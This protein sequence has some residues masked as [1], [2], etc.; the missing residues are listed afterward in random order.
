MTP[1]NRTITAKK[2]YTMRSESDIPILEVPKGKKRSE[3]SEKSEKAEKAEKPEKA[4]KSD[5]S[6]KPEKS[7]KAFKV[8]SANTK[9]KRGPARPHRR[10]ATE[11]IDL[12]ITKL[13]KR[14]DR[15]KSQIEDAGRHVEGYLR[16]RDFREKEAETNAANGT[17]ASPI[18]EST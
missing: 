15:A 16:E 10:L 6:E 12:R 7:K 3:K 17:N 18:A 13:Q 11:V 8:Q 9:P 14:L 1:I 4:D 5:K 2:K